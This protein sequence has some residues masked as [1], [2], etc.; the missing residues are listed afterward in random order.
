MSSNRAAG[1]NQL[2]VGDGL[3]PQAELAG[4]Q[5]TCSP[6]AKSRRNCPEN[7]AAAWRTET[8]CTQIPTEAIASRIGLSCDYFFALDF[9]GPNWS[10][11][12]S[13]C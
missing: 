6:G 13:Q 4:A 1:D 10:D 11:L 2:R 9:T 5:V 12:G 3:F 8:S 7:G